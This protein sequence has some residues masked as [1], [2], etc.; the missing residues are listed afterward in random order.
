MAIGSSA[1]NNFLLVLNR[2][3]D[4]TYRIVKFHVFLKTRESND[5]SLNDRWKRALFFCRT[6]HSKSVGEEARTQ[7]TTPTPS[8]CRH[9]FRRFSYV[10]I[11]MSDVGG[12]FKLPLIKKASSPQ[13]ILRLLIGHY[14][15]T[16]R[17]TRRNIKAT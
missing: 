4:V 2:Q 16:D 11:H 7:E 6:T 1:T 5:V 13:S 10:F 14:K 17:Q 15:V 3:H 9:S 12:R 8:N